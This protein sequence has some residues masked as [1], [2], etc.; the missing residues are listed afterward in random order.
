MNQHHERVKWKQQ[1]LQGLEDLYATYETAGQ[2]P[3]RRSYMAQLR[4]RI[5][6]GKR[7]LQVMGEAVAPNAAGGRR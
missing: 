4:S 2:A 6:S 3:A 7:E 1:R 5:Q